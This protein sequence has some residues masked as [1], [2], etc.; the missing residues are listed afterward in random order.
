[1]QIGDNGDRATIPADLPP[2]E[3]SVDKALELLRNAAKSD[4]VLGH[5]PETGKP[6]YVKIGRFGPYVQLGDPELTNKRSVKRGTKPKMASLWPSMSMET[7]TLAEAL[8]LLSFPRVVGRHPETGEEITAQDG[9]FGPYI[10]T[11]SETRSLE[12]HEQLRTMTLDQAVERLKQPKGRRRT[13]GPS[14]IADLGKHP[15]SGADLQVRIGRYGPYVTDGVVNA[16]IPKGRD[17]SKITL[18]D[19]VELIAAREQRLR[20]QGK[21]PRAPKARE[22]ASSTASTRKSTVK[23]ARTKKARSPNSTA[24]A[25]A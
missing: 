12:N 5:D 21:D 15:H 22:A 10:K 17:P 25:G 4:H 2:D 6:V 11:G 16:T 18:D 20:D 1:V 24:D 14:V 19:A 7:I 8:E 23:K 9:R 3:L 13:A